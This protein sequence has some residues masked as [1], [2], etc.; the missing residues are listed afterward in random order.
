[1]SK[2]N[3]IICT[4]M[5]FGL[6]FLNSSACQAQGYKSGQRAK[7]MHMHKDTDSV[8]SVH[9]IGKAKDYDRKEI[10]Y[11]GEA[12]GDVMRRGKQYAWVNVSDGDNAIGIWS[13]WFLVKDVTFLG[14]YKYKGD[15]LETT[16][17]FNRVCIEHGGDLDIHAQKINILKKGHKVEHPVNPKKVKLAIVLGILVLVM[18]IINIGKR[19]RI[20]A[21][22][23]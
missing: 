19:R 7:A 4:A 5:F 21:S 3:L 8:S 9:L 22:V 1:M 2:R 6:A 10:V 14:S 12:I 16:G 17:Q 23:P 20:N 18:G 11:E 15:I 13:P